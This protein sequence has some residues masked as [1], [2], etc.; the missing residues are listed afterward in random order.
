MKSVRTW[1]FKGLYE[2]LSD[3]IR[4]KADKSFRLW[5]NDTTHPR[6]NF[7]KVDDEKDMWSARV[8]LNHR[9]LCIKTTKDG[10][11]CFVWFWIG[12]HDEYERLINS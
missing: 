5:I 8:D 9:A 4:T 6:L 10:E 1:K 12:G 11:T 3:E 2:G 7:E